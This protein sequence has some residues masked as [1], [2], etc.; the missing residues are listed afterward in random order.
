[1]TRLTARLV[2]WLEHAHE[3]NTM[4]TGDP[5]EVQQAW[6]D[7]PNPPTSLT[8][9]FADLA[10]HPRNVAPINPTRGDTSEAGSRARHPAGK[11]TSLV[12]TQAK[13]ARIIDAVADLADQWENDADSWDGPTMVNSVTAAHAY[14]RELRDA[15]D[16]P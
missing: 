5:T 16:T 15:L 10:A 13:F 6:V 4:T 1:M 8:Q 12:Q 2:A 14:V 11:L 3:R 7:A 9:A